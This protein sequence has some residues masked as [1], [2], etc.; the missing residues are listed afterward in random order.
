MDLSF[1]DRH[2]DELS[3]AITVVVALATA[4]VVD[5]LVVRRGR[6]LAGSMARGGISPEIET[7]LR[8]MRRLLFATIVVIGLALALSQ[9]ES[10]KRLATGVLA[11]TAVL[12]LVIGF[13]ARQTLANAVAGVL[14]AITQ[15]VRVGDYIAFQ[16]TSGVVDDMT[17]S[18]TYIDTLDGSRTVVP[19]E[20]LVTAVLHNRTLAGPEGRITVSAWLPRG[21]DIGAA[22]NALEGVGEV[23]V[24]ELSA[25]GARIEVSAPSGEAR[26]RHRDASALRERVSSALA[27][28]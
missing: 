3:A 23:E 13:A 17:L 19:N 5:W 6:A 9:F 4:R 2:G 26:Y 11:S 10:I 22:R 21:V 8:L 27:A 28:L 18:Y 16:E 14:L 20:Q 12:G 1:W 24:A 25:D 7:R 15:P